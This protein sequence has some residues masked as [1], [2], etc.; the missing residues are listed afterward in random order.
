ML[1]SWFNSG[2]H[3]A[4]GSAAFLLNSRRQK[5]SSITCI[6]TWDF[7]CFL[8]VYLKYFLSIL[9]KPISLDNSFPFYFCFSLNDNFQYSMIFFLYDIKFIY[10]FFLND[11]SYILIADTPDSKAVKG[12]GLDFRFKL[13]NLLIMWNENIIYI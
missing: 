11:F 9:T 8:F 1:G 10:D 6:F 2:Y 13:W 7:T 3:S 5:I 12:I 4:C